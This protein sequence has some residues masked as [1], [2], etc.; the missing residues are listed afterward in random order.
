MYLVNDHFKT[1]LQKMAQF[2]TGYAKRM[3][4][5]A[6]DSFSAFAALYTGIVEL[7]DSCT[8]DEVELKEV[9]ENV[10]NA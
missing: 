6:A 2:H 1:H 7:F 9:T 5:P 3:T 10:K 4:G 8:I